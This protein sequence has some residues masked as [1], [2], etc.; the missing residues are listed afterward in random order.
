MHLNLLHKLLGKR[1]NQ[2][3]SDV[4]MRKSI[5]VILI[6]LVLLMIIASSSFAAG[7]KVDTGIL[8]LPDGRTIKVGSGF[9]L[10]QEEGIDVA[11]GI[12]ILKA[13]LLRTEKERDAYKEAYE[14]EK[15]TNGKIAEIYK[16]LYLKYEQKADLL[17]QY[18]AATEKEIALL[19][20]ENSALK[21][22]SKVYKTSSSLLGIAL[23]ISLL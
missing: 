18:I 9:Y 3:S 22:E 15:E 2:K 10:T 14:R 20:G 21:F 16:E 11:T 12:E 19:K 6:S 7:I 13:D 8:T 23:I 4:M 17:E 5:L 1:D